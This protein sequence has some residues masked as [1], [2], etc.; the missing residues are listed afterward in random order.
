MP[1]KT[2][3]PP[4]A[5][6]GAGPR[7]PSSTGPV[8]MIPPPPEPSGGVGGRRRSSTRPG[9][10]VPPP[11]PL[12]DNLAPARYVADPYDSPIRGVAME[13]VTSAHGVPLM[14]AYSPRV[15]ATERKPEQLGG[16]FLLT[17][18]DPDRGQG[19]PVEEY[20]QTKLLTVLTALRLASNAATV[21]A[22]SKSVREFRAMT[23]V[24]QIAFIDALWDLI[25]RPYPFDTPH[26]EMV[27]PD[28]P[29][30]ATGSFPSSICPRRPSAGS[31]PSART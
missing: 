21:L 2:P 12:D 13:N 23:R 5:F 29:P 22:N 20:V 17:S 9:A 26:A 16:R 14:H 18:I 31:L 7:R 1:G 11:P 15:S 30:G 25:A 8:G 27:D 3:S 10:T 24:G 6:G 28:N 19:N 4:D